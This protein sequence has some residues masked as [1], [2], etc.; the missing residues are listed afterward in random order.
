VASS[1]E[2]RPDSA[3]SRGPSDVSTQPFPIVG[4]GASAGGLEAFSQLLARLPAKTGMAFVLVQ[5]LDPKHESHLAP[6]L[7]KVA[8]MPVLEASDNLAV[9]PDHI[10]V[11]PRNTVLSIARGI[12]HLAPRGED[13]GHHLPIDF[14]FRS[15]AEDRGSQAV[16]AVLSGTGSDGTFGV[17]AIKANGGITFA[18][19]GTAQHGG[20]PRSA[21]NCGAVDL[22][23]APEGIADELVRIGKHPYVNGGHAPVVVGETAPAADGLAQLFRLLRGATRVDYGNYKRST[24]LRR[25]ERRLVLHRFERLED[26][27]TYAKEHP[28]ELQALHQDL[29]IHV[30]RFFRDPDVFESLGASV[31]P[32][33]IKDRSPE[34]PVRI[35]VPGCS[36]GEEVYSLA[37]QLLEALGDGAGVS[38]AKVFATDVSEPTLD[39][40]RAG[41][42]LENIVEDVSPERL[43]RFFI[44]EKGGY[45]VHKALRDLCIFAQ[46]DMTRD[47]P[48]SSLDLISCR[49][50]LIYLG[51]PLQKRVLP[52]FHYALR[53]RGIL[54]LGSSETIGAPS[55]LFTVVDPHLKIYAKKATSSRVLFDFPPG[56][57]QEPWLARV[58]RTQEAVNG[59]DLQREVD[60]AVLA[61]YAP[62]GVVI[63]EAGEILQFRGQTGAFLA[64]A[65]G[66]ASLNL[67]KMAREGLLLELRSAI[68]E[69]KGKGTP[70]RR[71]GL[72]VRANGHYVHVNV[73]VM[74]ISI[75]SRRCFGVLFENVSDRPAET[76]P[77]EG[78][79]PAPS[80]ELEVQIDGG[81]TVAQL[82]QELSGTKEY[83]QSL[84][85]SLE[86]SN[87]ELKAANEEILSGNE[88]LQS[89]NEE[90][91]TS[92]E[93]LQ[94][95]NEELNT[96]NEELQRR[97]REATQL[98]D[99]LI[100]LLRSVQIPIVMVGQDLRIRRFSPSAT[101]IFSLVPTDV[102]RPIA[103]FK[104]KLV[105]VDLERR[106]TQ[107]LESLIAR[108]DDVRDQ[109]GRWHHLRIRPYRTEQNRIDGVVI[110]LTDVDAL[111]R[112]EQQL[113][114]ARRYAES[115]IATVQVPLL[116][117]DQ[118][119]RVVSAN[120]SFYETFRTTPADTE[121]RPLSE[122][123]DGQW[124]NSALVKLLGD[125]VSRDKPFTGFLVEQDF[126]AIG[127]KKIVLTGLRLLGQEQEPWLV[128][129]ALEDVTERH[130]LETQLRHAQKMEAV[131][132]LAAGIAHD[133]NNLMTVING[134]TSLLLEGPSLDAPIREMVNDIAGAGERAAILT[135]QLL[136][137]SRKQ[138]LAPKIID[139]NAA[140]AET[141][142]M[143][144]RVIG[145]HIR[146]T[147]VV[148]PMLGRVFADPAVVAE[149]L[150]NLAINS[151]DAMPHGGELSIETRNLDLDEACARDHPDDLPLG[152]YVLLMMRDTGRGM[153]GEAIG[154][155]FEPSF[156]TKDAGKGSGLGL[157]SVYGGIKQSG[158][159]IRVQ[160][161][162]GQ[163]TTFTIYLPRLPPSTLSEPPR[164]DPKSVPCGTETVL[165]VEDADDVRKLTVK[166]LQM[167]GY[168][169]LDAANGGIAVEMAKKHEGPIQ[170]LLSDV[171]MPEMGGPQLADLLV[172]LR[173]DMKVLFLSGYA[174]K[175]V[176]RHATR[177]GPSLL[178]Q[179]PYTSAA[180]LR[181]VREVLDTGLAASV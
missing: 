14:F 7:A 77:G 21:I 42:Y 109:Q 104:P 103:D 114:R 161:H 165:L 90:L 72:R 167:A 134:Y 43:R 81:R 12:L 149:A 11:I 110:S 19:D 84:I 122:W 129:L 168:R 44:E 102:N 150:L 152:P 39:R 74:P 70:T 123:G 91:Q 137:F 20:M 89:T 80:N 135:H 156:T 63:D 23:L 76:L 28:D 116:V 3:A 118:E 62:P 32:A 171:V 57:T 99:D 172:P 128:L 163:G 45:R 96:V 8:R 48:F 144:R 16:G 164:S 146:L 82:E 105:G 2:P 94:A 18:Q 160:S 71:K 177:Q 46:H 87:E 1:E 61:R 175:S 40:A 131:G 93:E 125:A 121:W 107:V 56:D 108:E 34:T 111:K 60:R 124:G 55:E 180:L 101:E 25:I 132:H 157:P 119:L 179:K 68:E 140:V 142:R 29:L 52:L 112:S 173:P 158:G 136:A 147:T 174:E 169:V 38:P 30:T 166:M 15:L 41:R 75:G 176:L 33:M 159:F 51:A 126:P 170:L 120:R 4:I 141:E 47:P 162:P 24:V 115:I 92:K 36:T 50:V 66:A 148:E 143:L 9:T 86:T 69:A 17:T 113:Q 67:L 5:H 130:R 181:R 6:L 22:V 83:L 106:I 100:N 117:L 59:P 155:I 73:E 26:Y 54:V 78:T 37:I 65:P 153:S 127:H 31:F 27:A 53:D 151:R 35:W 98:S 85:E 154:R 145:E 138:M 95:S 133:F 13:R 178:L 79:Q 58:E 64:P 88:E 49:N 97:N 10:Y 139:V